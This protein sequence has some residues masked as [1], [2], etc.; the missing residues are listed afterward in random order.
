[1]Y[2][3]ANEFHHLSSKTLPT[4]FDSHTIIEKAMM[5]MKNYTFGQLIRFYREKEGLTQEEL[6]EIIHVTKGKLSHWEND[7]T[8]PRPTMVA[9]LIGSLRIPENEVSFL[10]NAVEDASTRK[11]QEEAE[12]QAIVD[13]Q[14]KENERMNHKHK[15]IH[16]LL[17][18]VGGFMVGCLIV[19]LT[20]SYKDRPWYFTF[21]IGVLIAGIPYGWSVLTDKS[22]ATY[23]DLHYDPHNWLFNLVIK[24][25]ILLLKFFGAYLIGVFAY[26]IVLLYHAYKSTKKGSIYRK[27]IGT[28]MFL[29]LLFVGTIAFLIVST[30]IST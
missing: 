12:A 16:L 6:A 2:C 17:L 19:F 26:P 29:I 13:K 1:M 5:N 22:E 30:S 28:I 21:I 24:M 23:K 8:I 11:A 10:I 3:S 14:N 20:G 15:A 9:R 18:G 25:F 27:I 4:T 7:E